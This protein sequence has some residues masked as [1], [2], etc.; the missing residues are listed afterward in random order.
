MACITENG[1]SRNRSGSASSSLRSPVN[2]LKSPCRTVTTKFGPTKIMISPVSTIS[3]ASAT[4]S[5]GTYC[6]VLSTRNNVS[7]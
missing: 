3:R 2:P 4:D 5:W 6:T 7:S 1:P